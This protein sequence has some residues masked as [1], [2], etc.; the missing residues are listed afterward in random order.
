MTDFLYNIVYLYVQFVAI[1]LQIY[2]IHKL[3]KSTFKNTFMLI[4]GVIILSSVIAL[5][6][7]NEKIIIK[8]IIYFI[9]MI[10]ICKT[11]LK[12]DI[13]NTFL[14]FTFTWLCCIIF[15]LLM[16]IIFSLCLVNINIMSPEWTLTSRV[17]ATIIFNILFYLLI[18]VIHRFNIIDKVKI[19]MKKNYY[20]IT[21]VIL[22]IILVIIGV[23]NYKTYYQNT[24]YFLFIILLLFMLF[25][26]IISIKLYYVNVVMKYNNINLEK[27]NTEYYKYINE[28]KLYKHNI[29]YQL[30]AVKK[31]GNKKVNNIIDGLI[32]NNSKELAYIE[33]LKNVPDCFLGLIADRLSMCQ[34]SSTKILI[35]N[36]FTSDKL[37]KIKEKDYVLL[38]EALGNALT[39]AI[40]AI[41][42]KD[43]IIYI[44]F[45]EKDGVQSIEIINNF[46]NDINIDSIGKINYSTKNRA[47]GYGLF[48][49]LDN[50]KLKCTIDIKNNLFIV[51]I[52]IP[53]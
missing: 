38:C 11:S 17:L 39:N 35:E 16:G 31:Y 32:D 47:S 45:R 22:F 3:S 15:D 34:V 49:M 37:K 12:T 7:V 21:S 23:I 25:V 36:N 27:K 5:L 44:I 42:A 19:F 1:Y 43:G 14:Y 2:M 51:K 10:I 53:N 13:A 52:K 6:S 30:Y 4:I 26:I 40:E 28:F 9:S 33:N 46:N 48:S 50:Q 8:E 20:I 29:K 24:T 41:P 18:K